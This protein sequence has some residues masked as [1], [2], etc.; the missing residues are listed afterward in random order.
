MKV[1]NSKF[2]HIKTTS[3]F[4][5][6]ELMVVIAI[7]GIVSATTVYS[8]LGGNP[9]RRVRGASRDLYAGFREASAQAVNRSRN[10]TITFNFGATDSYTISDIGGNIETNTFPAWID[11]YNLAGGSGANTFVYNSRGMING[12]SGS[13]LI[14][15]APNNNAATKMGVRVTSAGG[16][17]LIDE[18]TDP[19]FAW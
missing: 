9:D 15:Y 5:L 19:G 7:I 12:I 13:L 17:S 1:P 10:V 3:G 6:I 11:L 16:I 8:Y 18:T 2:S 4:T 14:Q